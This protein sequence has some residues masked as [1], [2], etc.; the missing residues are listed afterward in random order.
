MESQYLRHPKVMGQQSS[1]HAA[2]GLRDLMTPKC[3]CRTGTSSISPP[4][5]LNNQGVQEGEEGNPQFAEIGK[6]YCK[7]LLINVIKSEKARHAALFD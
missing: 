7:P 4:V 3:M 6:Y 1:H 5:E 2:A